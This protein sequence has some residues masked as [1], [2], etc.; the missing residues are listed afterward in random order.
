MRETLSAEM[1]NDSGMPLNDGRCPKSALL[2]K[3]DGRRSPDYA[4]VYLR[5][6]TEHQP[7]SIRDQMDNIRAH[8]RRFGRQLVWVFSD[9][10][11]NN[12]IL[13]IGDLFHEQ[14]QHS[15]AN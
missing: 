7:D 11:I 3:N 9:Q 8:A 15:I 14:T 13:A 10:S 2:Q 12:P 1:K 4:G 6:S 5:K